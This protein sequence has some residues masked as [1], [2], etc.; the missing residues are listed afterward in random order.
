M[1]FRSCLEINGFTSRHLR[2][3]T[4]QICDSMCT[5]PGSWI[6]SAP[7]RA[8]ARVSGCES[9]FG[10]QSSKQL[11][12]E[13]RWLLQALALGGG[14]SMNTSR[15]HL[16]ERCNVLFCITAEHFSGHHRRRVIGG[17]AEIRFGALHTVGKGGADAAALQPDL[18]RQGGR[19]GGCG[20]LNMS[21]NSQ[22]RPSVTCMFAHQFSRP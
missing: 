12:A 2:C 14:D 22:L 1:L 8:S 9:S 19:Y 3:S 4:A 16:V 15:K 17:R 5:N 11:V 21:G 10:T 18:E 6:V 7:R 20:S 13:G